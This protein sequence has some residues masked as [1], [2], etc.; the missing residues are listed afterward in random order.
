MV[1]EVGSA[2]RNLVLVEPSLD[3]SDA[4]LD[5][6]Q[7]LRATGQPLADTDHLD[8]ANI[9]A[10]VRRLH[11]IRDGIGLES[12]QVRMSTFWLLEEG[13]RI[14]GISRIRHHLTQALRAHGGHIGFLVRPS[15]RRQSYGVKLLALSLARA[16]T[17]GIDRT[18]VTCDSDNYGSRRIIEA[19]GGELE[20][21]E[22]SAE[23]GKLIRR[24]WIDLGHGR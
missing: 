2:L 8:G 13:T 5:L 22:V 16:R 3:L 17:L 19:N 23:S 18:L 20:V 9:S 24:Y 21:E 1:A 11:D 4:F 12:W 14:V 7:E 6:V 10:Y 15:A